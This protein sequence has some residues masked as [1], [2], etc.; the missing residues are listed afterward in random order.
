MTTSA[1]RNWQESP[2]ALPAALFLFLSAG[3]LLF[4]LRAFSLG[5]QEGNPFLAFLLDKGLF[6]PGKILLSLVLAAIMMV[7]L[8][9]TKRYA[10]VVWGGV[11]LMVGV[12]AIHVAALSRHF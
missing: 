5:Y 9:A 1:M 8:R 7:I 4:S 6:L 3:D 10:G 2:G 12:N 11:A